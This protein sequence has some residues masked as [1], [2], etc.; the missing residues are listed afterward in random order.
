MGF[1][2]A[3]TSN[4]HEALVIFATSGIELMSYSAKPLIQSDAAAISYTIAV[5]VAVLFTIP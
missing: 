1:V 2:T 4:S 5:N 3:L